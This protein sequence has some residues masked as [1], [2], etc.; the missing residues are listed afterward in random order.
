MSSFL[1]F[2]EVVVDDN[3]DD[4]DDYNDNYNDYKYN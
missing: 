1:F 3:E 4:N 2:I